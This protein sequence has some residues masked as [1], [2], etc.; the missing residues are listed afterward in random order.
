ML[1]FA[2]LLLLAVGTVAQN[3]EEEAPCVDPFQPLSNVGNRSIT[4][5]L[6]PR[7]QDLLS[8]KF[9]DM[10]ID[11]AAMMVPSILNDTIVELYAETLQE[12]QQVGIVNV[13]VAAIEA[14]LTNERSVE[15]SAMVTADPQNW[16]DIFRSI[17]SEIDISCIEAPALSIQTLGVE[18]LSFALESNTKEQVAALVNVTAVEIIRYMGAEEIVAQT[19]QSLIEQLEAAEGATGLSSL[20]AFA[21]QDTISLAFS[22]ALSGI[23]MLVTPQE[24]ADL[25]SGF[26]VKIQESLEIDD[27]EVLSFA[28]D[29]L[30]SVLEALG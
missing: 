13:V 24:S 9:E 29:I 18:L 7:A 28:V 12:E 8:G 11:Q 22:N 25:I 4:D 19:L 2:F 20:F 23:D 5:P 15:I 3:L 10:S 26:Y 21:S 6:V 1:R 14:F 17:I 30:K 27:E 16:A